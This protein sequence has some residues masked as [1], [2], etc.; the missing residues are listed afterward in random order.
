MA[1]EVGM[2]PTQKRAPYAL[3]YVHAN[4]MVLAIRDSRLR[5]KRAE[6]L[7]RITAEKWGI[8]PF[9]IY[10]LF[11]MEKDPVFAPSAE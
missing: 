2:K 11:P 5:T 9:G 4:K 3:P 10:S 1:P 8:S 6:A 7:V